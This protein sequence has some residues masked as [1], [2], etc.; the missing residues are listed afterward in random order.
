MPRLWSSLFLLRTL[1]TAA[2]A[3]AFHAY[4]NG[5]PRVRAAPRP[6]LSASTPYSAAAEAAAAEAT[7]MAVPSNIG[8][9]IVA[10][11]PEKPGGLKIPTA[12]PYLVAGAAI[13]WQLTGLLA[14]MSSPA[15]QGFK[16]IY[17]GAIA[18]VI[19]RTCCAPLEMVSTVMMCRG[20][21][22]QSM[23][24]EL[25]SAYKKAG[26][27]GLFK[28]NGAN[29]LKVAPS[30]GMQFLVYEFVKQH[31]VTTGFLVASAG[32]PLNAGARLF[33]GGIAGM[34]AAALVYPLEVVKTMLTLYPEDCKGVRDGLRKAM[35]NGGLPGMY[36]G[37]M[38]TLVAMFP[39]VGVE[40]MVYETLK[41]RW[42]MMF[43]APTTM[44]LL[45]LGAIGGAA[46]Q[47]SAH[48]LDVVRR[49]MQMQSMKKEG[50]QADQKKITNM[51]SGL[52][53]IA[54]HE[55]PGTLFKGLGPACLEKMPSTAIGYYIYEGLKAALN[56]VSV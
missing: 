14:T 26:V 30:R 50:Q 6:Q 36:R 9:Q 25:T 24:L 41:R 56:V 55:G 5:A 1:S 39:Y 38:P 53:G 51:V 18:G 54:K 52:Y 19:S 40:F 21:A 42:L 15:A 22:S 2:P 4:G 32:A 3:E 7:P 17:A 27:A 35:Q 47:T 28:G 34:A 49:R 37:L 8:D 46:A 23:W 33:A 10:A 45:L 13:C 48:P 44:V 16:L 12:L 11:A 43:G 29:C 20:Q 31:M